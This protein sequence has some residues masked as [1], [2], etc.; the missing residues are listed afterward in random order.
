MLRFLLMLALVM[1]FFRQAF[2][3]M[4][5]FLSKEI[6]STFQTIVANQGGARRETAVSF[7]TGRF[8]SFVVNVVFPFC[9][10]PREKGIGNI[11]KVLTQT[12]PIA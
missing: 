8:C 7:R 10:S 6:T 12:S 2:Y 1:M 3:S 11:Q 5:K 9:L 4:D